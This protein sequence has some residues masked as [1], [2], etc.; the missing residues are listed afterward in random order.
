MLKNLEIFT[1][2]KFFV[3]CKTFFF[4]KKKKGETTKKISLVLNYLFV[5]GRV[6]GGANLSFYLMDFSKPKNLLF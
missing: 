2:K 6:G 3:K 4:L 5:Q 1:Q